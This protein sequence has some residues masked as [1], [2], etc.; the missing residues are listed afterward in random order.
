LCE[1]PAKLQLGFVWYH[2]DEG[3]AITRRTPLVRVKG[4]EGESVILEA[5]NRLNSFWK[6]ENG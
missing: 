5:R 4:S 2:G 1:D 3:V 6:P